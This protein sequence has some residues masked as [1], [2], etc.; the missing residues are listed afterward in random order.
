[1]KP[2]TH[3]PIARA[4]NVG[5]TD[6]QHRVTATTRRRPRAHRP[7][8][9]HG[10][11]LLFVAGCGTPAP[12]PVVDA[13]GGD[14]ADVSAMDVSAACQQAAEVALSE[15]S[16]EAAW[17]EGE[18]AP[19]PTQVPSLRALPASCGVVSSS[20]PWITVD[21]TTR[22]VTLSPAALPTGLHVGSIE[23]RLGATTLASAPARLRVLRRAPAG[24][25]RRVLVVGID[26]ARPD[27]LEAA[28]TPWLDFLRRHGAYTADARTQMNGPTKSAPGWLSVFTGVSPERHRVV[29][30]GMYDGRDARYRTFVAR[31]VDAGRRAIVS[32]A[33]PEITSN[34]VEPGVTLDRAFNFDTTGATWLATR[35]RETDVDVYVQHF[36]QVDG[37]GHASG[38][39][40]DNPNYIVALQRVDALLGRLVDG[41]LARP[42]VAREDWLFVMTTDHGGRGMDHGPL[43]ADNQTIWFLVAG[44]AVTPGALPA[45][46]TSQMDVAPTVLRW[47]GV[48]L[49]PAW[50][51]EG[52]ARAVP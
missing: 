9:R 45:V 26:G 13:G 19:A 51:I 4:T 1:M 16:V 14:V 21:A 41:V 50:N 27:A 37:A 29:A 7:S 49:D 38:F 35:L 31:A 40:R 30:N 23:V 34:I 48:A 42:T 32:S 43:D 3:R 33:W 17:W 39:S 6:E 10:A 24:A 52:V 12:A 20:A 22:A 25:A 5:N 44:S 8:W 36:D 47:L 18:A 11:A 2:R 15:V 28:N 46:Q